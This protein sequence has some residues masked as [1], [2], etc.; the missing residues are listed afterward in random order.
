MTLLDLVEIAGSVLILSAFAASQ[1]RKL[2]PHSVSYLLFN[3]AGAAI[4]AGIA[5]ADR[6]WGFLLLEG[7]WT[8]VSAVSLV[9]V[10]AGR[11]ATT[12][13]TSGRR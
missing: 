5:A 3:I 7:T 11:R 8:I 1:V 6:S 10:L 9:A 2:D 12:E 4:L 13:E